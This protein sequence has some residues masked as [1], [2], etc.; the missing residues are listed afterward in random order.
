MKSSIQVVTL[1][2]RRAPAHSITAILITEDQRSIVT[3]SHEGQLCLW[4]LS[5]ELKITPKQLLFGHT[6]PVTC[7]AKARDFEKQ[8]YVVSAAENGEMCV[9]DITCG[10]CVE[11][12]RLPFCH[13]A[14]CY[15]HS[16][17]RMTGEGW[18]LCCGQY[19][20]IL[21]LDAKTLA[22]L[23]ALTSSHTPDWVSC[24][25]LVHSPR[26]QEDSL[27]AV[28]ATGVLSAWDL[29]SSITKIQEGQRVDERES[30]ALGC[31]SCQA[32]RFC[33][34]TERFLL[35]IFSTCWKVY[36]YCDFS[37]LWTEWSPRGQ[38]F[39]GGDVLA[40]HRLIVW[41][42]GG[43]GYI[44]Q[45]LNSGLS[46]SI[47]QPSGGGVLKETVYP[48]L[49]SSIDVEDEKQS[50]SYMMGF[51]NERKDPFYKIL[52]SGDASGRITLWHIPDV[53]VS[54]LDGS[55]KEIPRV[56]SSTLQ[57]SFDAHHLLMAEGFW[58]RLWGKADTTPTTT[59]T[60]YIP[61]LDMLVCG[62]E[63][64]R[65]VVLPALAAA[66]VC[67]LEDPSFRKDTLP[68]RTLSGHSSGVTALLYPHGRSAQFDPS[69]LLSGSQDSHVIWWDM[70]TGEKLHDFSL[71]AGRITDMLL[72]S[73]N[74][75]FKSHRLVCCLCGDHSVVLLHIQARRCLLEARKHLFPVKTLRWHPVENLLVVGCENG[76]IYI[77][78][79]ETGVL[80][81]HE[82]GE[83]AKAI[84]ASCE[85]SA[86]ATMADPLLRVFEEDGCDQHFG[87]IPASCF[88]SFYSGSCKLGSP[89]S[90][91]GLPSQAKSSCLWQ[92]STCPGQ[93]PFTILPVKTKWE[94]AN[95][96]ILLFDLEK[97]AEWLRSPPLNNLRS[98]N[99]FHSYGDLKRA[100]SS[101]TEKRTLVLRRNRTS[102][103][104]FPPGGP[105]REAGDAQAFGESHAGAA[106]MTR[107]LDQSGSGIKRHKKP[108]SSKKAKRQSSGK[109]N[110]PVATEVGKLLLS[111]LLPWGMDGEQDELCMRCLDIWRLLSPV[112][113]GQISR[114]SHL[115][116][117]L[118]GKRKAV[119]PWTVKPE[120]R[121]L[122][123]SKVLDLCDKYMSITQEQQA[124]QSSRSTKSSSERSPTLVYLL[125]RIC[126]VQRILRMPQENIGPQKPEPSRPK[127]RPAPSTGVPSLQQEPAKCGR[128]HASGST[129]RGPVGHEEPAEV[130]GQRPWANG[131]HCQ[132]SVWPW[133]AREKE[134]PSCAGV[135]CHGQGQGQGHPDLCWLPRGRRGAS[136][137]PAGQLGGF[138][139]PRG[140]EA[141]ALDSQGVFLQSVLDSCLGKGGFG[142]LWPALL[143]PFFH[144]SACQAF[145][146][147]LPFLASVDQRPQ[148]LR[149]K[150][151]AIKRHKKRT[152]TTDLPWLPKPSA[153]GQL[154][155]LAV[156][157]ERERERRP[158]PL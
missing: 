81:R 102:R 89:T 147:L 115:S 128:G 142:P 95:F 21:I 88:T 100:K 24:M 130:A 4:D 70:F 132:G 119:L 86:I 63:D 45:L 103:S 18:L 91:S 79:I 30:T 48:L 54:T 138:E 136:S 69:W 143:R 46:R 74:Y 131:H 101:A 98:S 47:Q 68:Y 117:A 41:T 134:E 11:D 35:V 49:L 39:A 44:Y 33:T 32:I 52:Y 13:T 152:G 122:F 111:C 10:E 60:L 28:S 3:G 57:E 26:I 75:Q 92:P 76:S 25:C 112:S 110:V 2:G 36:D 97:L 78:D 34:Y 67:L 104:L 23:H 22:V 125:S 149:K 139:L 116:L 56:A 9:W 158:F 15:Y 153:S 16:S 137:C 144:S 5:P 38:S 113:L 85:E 42:D 90:S 83:M 84:L 156:R 120:G 121:N 94:K 146:L 1:W 109:S 93:R 29:S 55:P 151:P 141:S 154:R 87:G 114:D 62:C 31:S 135:Q 126:L 123:S 8:P 19:D 106:P 145:S 155:V 157:M 43:H 12:T 7:L 6:A 82:S 20:N 71:H 96:H 127:W 73:E 108:K 58:G 129:G 14:I 37:L 65:I 80:E 133:P 27:I 140:E 66:K 72:S 53:P 124:R 150:C 40:A 118:P 64:G 50:F 17:F 61:S 99:S 105:A 77:W 148:T 51:M 107:P 59:F